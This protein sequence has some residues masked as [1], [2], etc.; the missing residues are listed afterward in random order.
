MLE[1]KFSSSL[2]HILNVVKRYKWVAQSTEFVLSEMGFA[3]CN[4]ALT[5]NLY[6]LYASCLNPEDGM[7]TNLRGTN[8]SCD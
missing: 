1:N 2:S 8:I 4:T 3:R 5:L 7:V 6:M